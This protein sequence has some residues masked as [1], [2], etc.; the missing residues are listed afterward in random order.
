MARPCVQ[1]TSCSRAIAACPIGPCSNGLWAGS[2]TAGNSRRTTPARVAAAMC[3]ESPTSTHASY[4]GCDG[5]YS[6]V[7][8][9]RSAA[10]RAVERFAVCE[11]R[12]DVLVL[13]LA[14]CR[15]GAVLGGQDRSDV[16]RPWQPEVGV[17]RM[18][19]E[20]AL[21]VVIGGAQI[22]HRAALG[23]RHE[24][25]AKSFGEIHRAAIDV[26]E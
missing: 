14:Q 16:V 1:A 13:R 10:Q 22:R 18:R 11:C 4:S 17:E 2:T 3:T 7:V 24:R 12:Q 25:V 19:A 6:R 15:C 20:L 26:V 9:E 23:Q 21:R 5:P 8:G